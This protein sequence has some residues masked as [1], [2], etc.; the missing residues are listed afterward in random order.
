MPKYPG[1]PAA[2]L[3][4]ELNAIPSNTPTSAVASEL[5]TYFTS[6]GL[7]TGSRLPSER[8]LADM[9]G[10]GRS[11]VREALAAL[12]ILGIVEVR[13]GSGTYLRS[14]IS[15]LLPQTLSWG[16]MVGGQ[17]IGDLVDI[18][19]SL[20]TLAARLAA[21]LAT[22]K[23]LQQLREHL[24]TMSTHVELDDHQAFVEADAHFHQTIATA[25]QNQAL[26]V[27]LQSVRALLRVWVE[28]GVDSRD[29]S[30]RALDEHTRVVEAI[31]AHDAEAAA[32]AM[33]THMATARERVL[34]VHAQRDH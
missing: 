3:H 6:G 32:G 29:D 30:R 4:G 14:N 24:T 28:R 2:E 33:N 17:E 10:T 15:E 1:D 23:D 18:R 7:E 26:A 9:L 22:D 11:A 13:P 12:E 34:S 21:S 8:K 19:T 27:V 31:A 5:L 16:L 20:E 25:S